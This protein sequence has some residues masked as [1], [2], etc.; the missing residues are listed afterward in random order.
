MES[1]KKYGKSGRSFY[2]SQVASTLRWLSSCSMSDLRARVPQAA[3]QTTEQPEIN[4]TTSISCSASANPQKQVSPHKTLQTRVQGARVPQELF[5]STEQ[6][7]IN[8]TSTISYAASANPQKQASSQ[9]TLQTHVQGANC[10]SE[11]SRSL[12]VDQQTEIV[13]SEVM[14]LKD[15][16]NLKRL[17]DHSKESSCEAAS[18]G[19]P[20][21][22]SFSDFMNKRHKQR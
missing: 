3:I 9:K 22:P 8:S 7:E 4:G 18:S 6:P 17:L 10:T 5:Q 12:P 13:S 21:I 20:T 11:V 16:V 14:A 15:K 1:F 2:N 19:L